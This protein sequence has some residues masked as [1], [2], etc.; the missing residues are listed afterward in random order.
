[1][2]PYWSRRLADV[3]PY[4]PGEQ[5]KEGQYIKLNTNENPYP[6]SPKALAAI[7][8]AA[9]EGLQR[10]AG[11][12]AVAGVEGAVGALRPAAAE[13]GNAHQPAR[14]ALDLPQDAGDG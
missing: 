10:A 1:M 7:A 8:A 12:A 11:P 14:L 6:P 9:G 13:V 5:P 2:N 3:E 4:V